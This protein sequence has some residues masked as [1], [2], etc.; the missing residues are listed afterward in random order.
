MLF[1]VLIL[2]PKSIQSRRWRC[3]MVSGNH[4]AGF[5]DMVDMVQVDWIAVQHNGVSEK[6]H[7]TMWNQILATQSGLL[8]LRQDNSEIFNVIKLN[9]EEYFGI[10]NWNIWQ[11]ELQPHGVLP[12]AMYSMQ[13]CMLLIDTVFSQHCCCGGKCR[14]WF[15]SKGVLYQQED[16]FYPRWQQGGTGESVRWMF[17]ANFKTGQSQTM[18]IWDRLVLPFHCA[19]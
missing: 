6:N 15:R 9:L 19:Y 13:R 4:G 7:V 17:V 14:E 3:M 8:A 16:I 1:A 10:I 12:A 2:K 5:I 18:Q 11:N